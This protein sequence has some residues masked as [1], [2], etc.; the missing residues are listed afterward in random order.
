MLRILSKLL[1]DSGGSTH[2]P[3]GTTDVNASVKQFLGQGHRVIV[4]V[5][6][7]VVSLVTET[8]HEAED[9][10]TQHTEDPGV[11][12][13]VDDIASVGLRHKKELD[14]ILLWLLGVVHFDA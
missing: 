14:T 4:I 1:E 10:V 3:K 6:K 9:S 11:D 13:E 7:Q 8:I 12:G 5:H 2:Q